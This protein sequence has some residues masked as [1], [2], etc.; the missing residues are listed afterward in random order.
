MSKSNNTVRAIVPLKTLHDDIVRDNPTFTRT[1]KQMRVALRANF[2]DIHDRNASWNFNPTDYD[3]VRSHFDPTY[4]AK[5]ARAAKRHTKSTNAPRKSRRIRVA[6][7][8]ADV[9]NNELHTA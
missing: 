7:A 3:R 4:A 5:I 2:A 8:N 9:I 1:T 6:D